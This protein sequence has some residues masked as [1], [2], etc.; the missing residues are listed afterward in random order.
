[1][2][3]IKYLFEYGPLIEYKN[4]YK[5]IDWYTEKDLLKNNTAIEMTY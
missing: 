5:K 2:P 3:T 1:M 4:V